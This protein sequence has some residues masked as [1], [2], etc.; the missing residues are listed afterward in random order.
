[1]A[2]RKHLSQE[3]HAAPEKK[4]EKKASKQETPSKGNEQAGKFGKPSKEKE[5]DRS[6]SHIYDEHG[7]Y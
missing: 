2:H 5:E 6:N 1:M 3:G 7:E 4:H